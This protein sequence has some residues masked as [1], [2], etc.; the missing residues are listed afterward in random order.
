[1]YIITIFLY[2]PNLA[3]KKSLKA[4][5]RQEATKQ[6]NNNSRP[7][8]D[9]FFSELQKKEEEEE[10]EEEGEG[11]CFPHLLPVLLFGF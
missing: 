11:Y 6:N 1:M 9:S 3:K 8:P 10:E 5:N 2:L 4:P 7:H